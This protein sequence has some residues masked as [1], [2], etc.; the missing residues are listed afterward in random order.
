MAEIV[1]AGAVVFRRAV[2]QCAFEKVICVLS[3]IAL[4][5]FASVYAG[6]ARA[7]IDPAD[8]DD[9]VVVYQSDFFKRYRPTTALEMVRRIPGFIIDDG[10][11]KRGFGAAAGNILINDR[12]PSAKQD[13]P[14]ALLERIPANLVDRIE[15]IR[16]QVRGIDLRGQPVVASVILLADIP[17]SGRWDLEVRKI[18][19]IEPYT[20][21]GSVSLSDS[22]R[23]VEYIAGANYRRF[24]SG[25]TGTDNIHLPD[26]SL[27]GARSRDTFLRGDEG[28][29]SMSLLGWLGETVVST[30]TRLEF[31]ERI[32]RFA[33]LPQ[34]ES[35][36]DEFFTEGED[37][38]VLEIGAD[39]ERT[40]GSSVFAKG[41]V[42][43][44]RDDQNEIATQRTLNA[45]GSEILTRVADSNV[46]QTESIA[47]TEF[48][49]TP[50]AAYAVNFN[51]EAARNAIDGKLTQTVDIGSG[52]IEVPVPGGNTR[53]EEDRFDALFNWT[54]YAGSF[55]SGYGLGAEASTI[56]QTGDAESKRSFFFLKPQFYVSWSPTRERQTRFRIAREVAQLDFDDFIS[57]TVFQDDDVALG[58][59]DLEPE[60]TWVLELSEERR[61]GDLGVIKGTLFYNDIS[62]AQDL[63]PLSPEFEAPGN[64]GAGERWGLRLEST[65]PLDTVGLANGR[66]DIEAIVQDSRVTDPVTGTDRILSAAND[67]GKPLRLDLETRYSFALNL[68]QDFEHQRFAWGAEVRKRGERTEFRVNERVRYADGYEFNLF[69]ETTRWLGLKV[70]I[71]G[72]NL[73]NFEQDRD[74]AIFVGER[75]L[76]PIEIVERRNIT[77][78]RRVIVTVSGSY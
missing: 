74:R 49:W 25:E 5:F 51:L 7:D 15:L 32:D 68:R 24:R 13:E 53:V 1:N 19:G 66:L 57:A 30:N 14:S 56:R 58:N 20:L 22:W 65:L 55:E 21:R 70:R 17:A 8:I 18:F 28:S 75:D 41:I 45:Q 34:T 52:P 44:T 73:L 4:A 46:V 42:L 26:G 2:G 67:D 27:L 12:Y 40:F 60:S 39:A 64:I 16:G 71:D 69:A 77:D 61:F 48:Y 35:A 62:D 50:S 76:T 31:V 9:E 54:V 23:N 29:A 43:H 37:G 11:D 10:A 3:I 6:E 72:I 38:Y 59:P 47:R 63:L 33:V 36:D 78:G